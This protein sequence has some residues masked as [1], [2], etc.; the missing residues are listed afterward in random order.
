MTMDAFLIILLIIDVATGILPDLFR[1]L[2]FSGD[3]YYAHD[4]LA[5]R[6]RAN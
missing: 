4:I 3:T 2:G 6:T 1:H 5:Q